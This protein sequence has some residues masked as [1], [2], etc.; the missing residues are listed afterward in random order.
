MKHTTGQFVFQCLK[1]DELREQIKQLQAIIK[2]KDAEIASFQLKVRTQTSKEA[3]KLADLGPQKRHKTTREELLDFEL[4]DGVLP[5]IASSTSNLLSSLEIFPTVTQISNFRQ[6]FLP[7]LLNSWMNSG[8]KVDPFVVVSSLYLR[9]YN[10]PCKAWDLLQR[11]GIV[12]SLR[13]VDD[14]M[15]GWLPEGIFPTR[16]IFVPVCTVGDNCQI[17]SKVSNELSDR[18]NKMM[19]FY[20]HIELVIPQISAPMYKTKVMSNPWIDKWHLWTSYAAFAQ[21]CFTVVLTG[22]CSELG[23]NHFSLKPVVEKTKFEILPPIMDIQTGKNEDMEKVIKQYEKQYIQKD[24]INFFF[25]AGDQ[26][27]YAM[28]WKFLSPESKKKTFLIPDIFHFTGHILIA[29]YQMFGDWALIPIADQLDRRRAFYSK[30]LKMSDFSKLEEYF[31]HFSIA[32]IELVIE[33][34]NKSEFHSMEGDEGMIEFYR[35]KLK[36]EQKHCLLYFCY[37]Y[38]IPYWSQRAA[39][40]A[41]DALYVVEHLGYWY[42]LFAAAEKKLY[43]F[44]TLHFLGQFNRL[45][46]PY[47]KLVVERLLLVNPSGKENHFFPIGLLIEKVNKLTSQANGP[48]ATP[49]KIKYTTY[50]QNTIAP[51]SEKVRTWA[52]IKDRDT[53]TRQYQVKGFKKDIAKISEKLKEVYLV[54][55]EMGFTYFWN[56]DGSECIQEDPYEILEDSCEEFIEKATGDET[57]ITYTG[58]LEQKEEDTQEEDELSWDELTDSEDGQ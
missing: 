13:F 53:F 41:G 22:G 8:R 5:K 50:A 18:H 52:N 24:E 6:S 43:C 38:V 10:I 46:E 40:R 1:C 56:I 58:E 48:R 42:H 28:F 30:N 4:G 34:F 29:I 32:L 26:Q 15:Q 9:Q 51:L 25:Q 39:C 21:N 31:Y 36:N 20:N 37:Y 23:R 35:K 17:A 19:N 27:I 16:K 3:T 7:H 11:M 47:Q 45:H 57:N 33:D 49:F 12:S 14:L 54:E 2:S 44:L 55:K